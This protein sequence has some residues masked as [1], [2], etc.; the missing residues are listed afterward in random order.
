MLLFALHSPI[1]L[2]ILTERWK[3]TVWGYERPLTQTSNAIWDRASARGTHT[4]AQRA[5][6]WKWYKVASTFVRPQHQQTLFHYNAKYEGKEYKMTWNCELNL[7][8]H[9]KQGGPS[10]ES[11]TN[12]IGVSEPVPIKETQFKTNKLKQTPRSVGFY[13]S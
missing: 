8:I 13:I 11:L 12:I 6:S 9:A 5:G 1:A 4:Q 7:S 3:P 2:P 10:Q